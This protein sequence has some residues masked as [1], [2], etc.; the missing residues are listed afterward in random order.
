VAEQIGRASYLDGRL[1]KETSFVNVMDGRFDHYVPGR[2]RW[3]LDGA[4]ITEEE[5][6]RL[7]TAAG[8]SGG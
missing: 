4:E 1:V 8:G 2:H 6:E 5:A 7:I 3:L